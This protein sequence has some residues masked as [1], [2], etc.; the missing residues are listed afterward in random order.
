[1]PRKILRSNQS[2][3]NLKW[4]P[5]QTGNPKGRRPGTKNT[6]TLLRELL[7]WQANPELTNK[8]LDVLGKR[9]PRGTGPNRPIKAN[10]QTLMWLAQCSKALREEDTNAVREITDRLEGKAKTVLSQD[11]TFQFNISDMYLPPSVRRER[12]RLSEEVNEK[13]KRRRIA[14]RAKRPRKGDG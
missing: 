7:Q 1:M 12:E 3:S 6:K 11:G 2:Y 8:I 13:P 10:M 5:G 9:G 4:K 14:R